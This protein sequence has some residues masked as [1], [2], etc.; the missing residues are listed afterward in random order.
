MA[1]LTWNEP[2]PRSRRQI[3]IAER[4]TGASPSR[5]RIDPVTVSAL[6]LRNHLVPAQR[7]LR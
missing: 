4:M 2:A 1:D 3:G 5:D 7:S 6:P